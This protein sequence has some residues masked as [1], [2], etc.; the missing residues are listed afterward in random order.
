MSN[1]SDPKETMNSII[2]IALLNYDSNMQD[3][4]SKSFMFP[5]IEGLLKR[6]PV[7]QAN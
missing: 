5:L 4:Y 1:I 6:I 2:K 3:T 7:T